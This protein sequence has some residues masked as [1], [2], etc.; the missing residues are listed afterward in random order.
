MNQNYATTAVRTA[1]GSKG[2][3][4]TVNATSAKARD[5]RLANIAAAKA[6]ADAV[7]TS[8]GPRGMD[9]M[10]QGARG[11]V[12]IT[13][14]GATILDRLGVQ[15]PAAKMLVNL[16]KSQDIEA[17]D[18]TTT[19]VVI[20]GA[21]L[22]ASQQLL[23]RGI[24][25]TII[26]D[27]FQIA[28]AEALRTIDSISVPVS[29]SDRGELVKLATTALNSKIVSHYA[30]LLAP[31]AVDAVLHVA[32]R[33]FIEGEEAEAPP[34]AVD[35]GRIRVIKKL[36]GTLEDT[37]LFPGLV[38]TQP[39]VK[40]AGGPS[41]VVNA[42]V[43]LIQFCLS[44]PKTDIENNVIVQDYASMDR[45]LRE[46]RQHILQM[47]KKIKATG[48][49]V[50][51]IQKS[52]LRDATNDLSLHYLAK[53]KIMVVRDIERDDVG[54]ICKTLGCVPIAGLDTFTADKLAK[55]DVVEEVPLGSGE[56][57]VVRFVHG[58]AAALVSNINGLSIATNGMGDSPGPLASLSGIV[59]LPQTITIVVRGSNQLMLDEAERSL[60]DAL[61]V[62]RSLVR[63]RSLVPGGAAVETEVSVR[64]GEWAKTLSGAQAY[65]VKSYAEALET[66]PYTLAENAGL[67][68]IQV[69]T[70]LRNRHALGEKSAGINIRRSGGTVTDMLSEHVVQPALVSSSAFTL[71]T[72]AARMILKI[73]DIVITR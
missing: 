29:L 38:L 62:V 52:I 73:D 60:H 49:N 51:L 11:D 27:A 13:N 45:V 68:P 2:A 72:E 37:F 41:R 55:I 32:E 20:C 22:V 5:V 71:A 3:D 59:G 39:V 34:H 64:L 44:A 7:R 25:P 53:M 50:L 19:V 35:L 46:E 1:N 10:I 67:N 14:D 8:L 15:E 24:H 54:F 33:R 16:A 4:T 63:K 17:G 31:I 42:Q 48:C 23:E 65:C 30:G 6:V 28:C 61:C 43:A 69:I 58:P 9:K 47:C 40:S 66:I 21:L 26:S 57:K 12:L 36:G 56:E 18:G 70:E